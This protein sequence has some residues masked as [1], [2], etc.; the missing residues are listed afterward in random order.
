MNLKE[1][2]AKLTREGSVQAQQLKEA[3][4]AENW[5][6]LSP[7]ALGRINYQLR[8]NAKAGHSFA[9]IVLL[10]GER[11]IASQLADYYANQQ[12]LRVSIRG[13]NYQRRL[14]LI[15][16]RPVETAGPCGVD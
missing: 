16:W 8:Q 13:E 12:G 5:E 11:C 7:A 6:L 10:E 3:K 15:S 1:E 14:L 9:N 4:D 2:L